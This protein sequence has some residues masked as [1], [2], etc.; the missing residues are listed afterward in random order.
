MLMVCYWISSFFSL[1]DIFYVKLEFSA[2]HVRDFSCFIKY[3]RG[4][5]VAIKNEF[6]NDWIKRYAN[7]FFIDAFFISFFLRL[8]ID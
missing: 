3:G 5:I 1:F 2:F 8:S 4:T 7:L 6:T